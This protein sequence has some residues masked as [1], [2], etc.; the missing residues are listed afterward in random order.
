[1]KHSRYRKYDDIIE[2]LHDKYSYL[3]YSEIAREIADM[4]KD[5]RVKIESLRKYVSKYLNTELEVTKEVLDKNGNV[6]K[7]VKSKRTRTIEE[8]PPNFVPRKI[9]NLGHGVQNITYE[10]EKEE[11]VNEVLES[12]NRLSERIKQIDKFN[13]KKIDKTNNL[14]LVIY[15][16]DKH[17]GSTQD[18]NDMYKNVSNYESKMY[19]ITCTILKLKKKFGIFEDLL[20]F[21][22][23][24]AL[25][26]YNKKT[27]R[28][29]HELEQDLNN[30]EQFDKLVE[31]EIKFIKTIVESNVAKKYKAIATTNDNHSGDFSYFAWRLIFDYIKQV[32]NVDTK[33]NVDF[34]NYET[35]GR[36]NIIYTHGKDIKY[37]KNGLPLNLDNKTEIFIKQFILQHN[38]SNARVVKGDLHQS[39]FNRG[40]WFDYI[41][42]S[43]LI[44]NTSYTTT[45]FGKGDAGFYYEIFDKDKENYQCSFEKLI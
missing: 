31:T 35:I 27:T 4:F 41:N 3:S 22:L 1:M 38:L 14:T 44:A 2:E 29:G 23:G 8:I 7:T 21:D 11:Q 43:S 12:I 17:I 28:G 45:N 15:T 25:D 24:D 13:V 5:D 36:H 30:R 32:Y 9:V 39:S 6:I 20:Y 40:K 34:L 33:I 42:I 19:D 18:S 10:R 16:S 26:G 37:R